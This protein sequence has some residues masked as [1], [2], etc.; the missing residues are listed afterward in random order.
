MT[1]TETIAYIAERADIFAAQAGVG[2]M[3][4]AGSIISYLATHPEHIKAFLND[5]SMFD[6]PVGWHT[7]GNL[8]WHG[9]DGKI[10]GP[11]DVRRQQLIKRMEKGQAA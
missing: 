6:W 10:H 11:A 3:E 5:G 2:G 1:P 8:T 9:M 7:L 4:T